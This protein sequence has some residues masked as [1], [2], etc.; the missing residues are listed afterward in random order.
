MRRI[1]LALVAVA[2]MGAMKST[3]LEEL[4]TER[5][6]L[7]DYS[8]K[9]IITF[10]QPSCLPCKNQLNALKCVQE[11]RG[12]KVSVLAVQANGDSGELQRSLRP[13]HLNFPV[14]KGTPAFLAS[15]EAD[16]SPTPMTAIIAAGGKVTDRV[17]GAQSCEYW[18]GILDSQTA[19]KR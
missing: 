15:Y 6:T 13:L 3:R 16:Q 7:V 10:I 8:K 17:L 5:L 11:K 1:F 4:R 14:L 18:T 2:S 19:S 12:D 9:T